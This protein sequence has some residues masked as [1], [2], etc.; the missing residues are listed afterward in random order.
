MYRGLQDQDAVV[1]DKN[2][3]TFLLTRL[4]RSENGGPWL[5]SFAHWQMLTERKF[6]ETLCTMACGLM[7][8]S[9]LREGL[10]TSA[11]WTY[12]FYTIFLTSAF[13]SIARNIGSV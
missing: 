3:Q 8:R 10:R 12:S 1:M 13:E 6:L 11:L 5:R 2:L 4:L 9:K 7:A